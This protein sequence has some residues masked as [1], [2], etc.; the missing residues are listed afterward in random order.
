MRERWDF[1]STV[2]FEGIPLRINRRCGSFNSMLTE[3][4][5]I[6]ENTCVRRKDSKARGL[7][8][9]LQLSQTATQFGPE[10]T[11]QLWGSRS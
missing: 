9:A 1:A 4:A 6:F 5:N 10:E 11:T 2:C 3:I 8:F 7:L